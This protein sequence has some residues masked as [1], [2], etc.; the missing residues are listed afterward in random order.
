M[1][2][3][4]LVETDSAPEPPRRTSHGSYSDTGK[5]MFDLF[6]YYSQTRES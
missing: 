5:Y 4:A 1:P 3:Y 6:L 2:F